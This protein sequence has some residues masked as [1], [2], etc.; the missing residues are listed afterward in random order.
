MQCFNLYFARV[1]WHTLQ[2]YSVLKLTEV[3]TLWL[4][5]KLFCCL[6]FPIRNGR[7]LLRMVKVSDH[8]QTIATVE[9]DELRQDDM[10]K[11]L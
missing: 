11:I 4:R 6:C 10:L 7:S 2:T 5:F 9:M 8:K 1:W 3:D